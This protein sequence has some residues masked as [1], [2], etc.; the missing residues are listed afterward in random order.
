MI[1]FRIKNW[2]KH[3]HYKD[4]R[5]PW[6]KLHTS[7][8]DDYEFQQLTDIQRW[9]LVAIWLLASCSN[10][11]HP[12]GDPL[13]PEDER[14]LTNQSG[15][16]NKI[17]LKPLYSTGFLVRYQNDIAPQA[18]CP[19]EVE[20]YKEETE[21]ETETKIKVK[22]P[23]T[24]T[25]L[26]LAWNRICT[27]LPKCTKITDKRKTH[28]KARLKEYTMAEW[29]DVFTKIESNLFLCGNNDRGWKATFDWIIRSPD[30][31]VGVLEGKYDRQAKEGTAKKNEVCSCGKPSVKT[32]S[33]KKY[34]Q[35]CADK[36]L[37]G[38]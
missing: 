24:V 2:M 36:E 14:F 37:E 3:Q 38:V 19:L 17:D 6:I 11:F 5:P 29:E 27:S 28:A 20:A 12:D 30:N 7:L 35:T 10:R 31:V 26:S 34:C 1:Y 21:T 15:M 16:N 22:I 9:H 13:L 8:F 23:A 33:Y 18:D 4:R 25:D 32:I